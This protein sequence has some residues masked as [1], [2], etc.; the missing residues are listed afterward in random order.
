MSQNY[1]SLEKSGK[2]YE[3]KLTL[4]PELYETWHIL[5]DEVSDLMSLEEWL[6][7]T[8]LPGKKT[9]ILLCSIWSGLDITTLNYFIDQSITNDRLSFFYRLHQD[10]GFR[11][12][13]SSVNQNKM[14]HSPIVVT[15]SS[16]G[17]VTFFSG[18]FDKSIVTT[19]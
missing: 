10:E 1:F 3:G 11:L 19:Y 14:V 5:P 7:N 12:K 9:V 15:Y 2:G 6:R 17:E 18:V 8:D 4:P 16:Q 13:F